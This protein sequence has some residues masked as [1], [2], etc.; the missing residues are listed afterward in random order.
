MPGHVG[1]TGRLV[2]PVAITTLLERHSRCDV[3]ATHP[4]STCSSRRT[5]E[6]KCGPNPFVA[7]YRSR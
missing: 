3:T 1:R 6:P 7:R 5:S 2:A 4:P